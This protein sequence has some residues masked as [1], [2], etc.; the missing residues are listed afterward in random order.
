M[1]WGR[2]VT[3]GLTIEGS[4]CQQADQNG[5]TLL[6]RL[7]HFWIVLEMSECLKKVI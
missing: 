7:A 1:G 6:T 3:T 5:V 2:I 4:H